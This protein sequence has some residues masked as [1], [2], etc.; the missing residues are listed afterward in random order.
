MKKQN[1]AFF[2]MSFLGLG[3]LT[4]CHDYDLG[5][6]TQTLK[7]HASYD[8]F[9]KQFGKPDANQSWD[10][11]AQA[12]ESVMNGPA[13]DTRADGSGQSWSVRMRNKQPDYITDAVVQQYVK[14]LPEV[15]NNYTLGQ[16]DYTLV[17]TGSGEFT[18]S[19]INYGGSIET[20]KS[21]D[22][23]FYLCFIDPDTNQKVKHTLFV[24]NDTHDFT[25]PKLSADVVLPAGTEFWFEF[26][27]TGGND[28]KRYSYS[29]KEPITTDYSTVNWPRDSRVRTGEAHDYYHIYN[30]ISQLLYSETQ[31]GD[32]EIKRYMVIG[33]EDGWEYLQYLDFDYND[34]VLY[35][36]GDLPI[37]QAKRFFV[38][39][40]EEYD[41]DYND[42]MFDLEYR[43]LV[44]RA[45]GGTLP[46]RL[47]FYDDASKKW[48]MTEELHDLMAKGQQPA[49]S[50][51]E[52][53]DNNKD[54][55][56][57]INVGASNGVDGYL[58]AVIA[59]WT[60]P[61]TEEQLRVY[62]TRK[63]DEQNDIQLI[64]GD[65]EEGEDP[66]SLDFVNK[67]TTIHYSA[68]ANK[69]PSIVMG[70]VS[71]QWLK[72]RMII[73]SAYPTFYDGRMPA[74]GSQTIEDYWFSVNVISDN[75][76]VP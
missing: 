4:S 64:V 15:G 32:D 70:T 19:C 6:S 23:H 27:Y 22:F 12:I 30:G 24:G 11:Y 5:V 55:Y 61:L 47:R 62:G 43:R 65:I 31:Y 1:Y 75:L 59:Q 25:N 49:K 18:I 9:A 44:L 40:L 45:V 58:P 71:T 72:E 50:A 48:V 46:V 2:A 8:A 73:T 57:P 68:E 35:I 21:A 41:W 38:E 60:T 51:A 52:R 39:D 74:S 10:F 16:T 66:E 42:I 63:I 13:A 69:C 28:N 29:S 56:K 34:V 33:F 67:H 36:D 76:Y 37:P 17:S 14:L 3:V 7:D 53:V 26:D 54:W 20:Y